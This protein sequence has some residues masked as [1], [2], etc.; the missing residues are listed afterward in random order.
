MTHED[1]ERLYEGLHEIAFALHRLGTANAATEMGAIEALA[2]ELKDGSG[3]L[4]TQV[5]EGLNEMAHALNDVGTELHGIKLELDVLVKH[6]IK[7]K[8]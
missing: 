1:A 8:T 7:R 3:F 5:G 2:K 6:L 4:G